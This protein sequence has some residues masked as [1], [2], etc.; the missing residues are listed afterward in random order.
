M[1]AAAPLF[2]SADA[3]VEILLVHSAI[4]A[5][6]LGV[7]VI[8]LRTL[9]VLR[10]TGEALPGLLP[11]MWF[12][13]LTEILR[14][15]WLGFL[16]LG[17]PAPLSLDLLAFFT[18]FVV[19]VGIPMT[20]S[21]RYLPKESA[22]QA[23]PLSWRWLQRAMEVIALLG[24]T[25]LLFGVRYRIMAPI[26]LGPAAAYLLISLLFLGRVLFY[27]HLQVRRRPLLLFATFMVTGLLVVSV[28]AIYSILSGVRIRQSS[29]LSVFNAAGLTLILCAVVFL[30][31]N[32]RLADVVVKRCLAIVACTCASVTTWLAMTHCT[33]LPSRSRG[34]PR[35]FLCLGIIC[36]VIALSPVA[37][38]RLNLWVDAWVFQQPDFSAA[39]ARVWREIL[40]LRDQEEVFAK[41][42]RLLQE[43]LGLAAVNIIPTAAGAKGESVRDATTPSLNTLV[44]IFLEGKT[45]HAIA[46]RVG[47]VRPPLTQL[48]L[49]FVERVAGRI[50]I[51]LG[52]LLAAERARREALFREE[53]TSAELRALRAQV[54]PHFLFNSLN[55]IA[56]LAVIA[57]SRAEEMT[58]RLS[59][60]FRY[61]LVNTDRHFAS[62]NE[63]LEFARS[64]LDIE[65]MRFG[66]R[67]QVI[68]D[69]DPTTLSQPIPTLLL[70]PL[71]ENALK[72][73]L[74]PRRGGGTLVIASRSSGESISI[75]IADNGA[76]LGQKKVPSERSTGVGV[77]NVTNRLKLAYGGRAS[78]VLRPRETGGAEALIIIPKGQ[79][80]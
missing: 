53:L 45:E 70:Q 75:S 13:L 4:A 77:E 66:D 14:A 79:E 71:I 26:V 58:L 52:T 38:R 57:P 5:M 18:S 1:P 42:E 19:L 72:H 69:I 78:F 31:A 30:F 3:T 56:D 44:P 37:M 33:M 15:I 49:D 28:N 10:R 40:D 74:A 73:G 65:Q 46:L 59:A 55:T 2:I 61:V 24:F 62:L 35:E 9:L 76:G 29:P 11:M 36:A 32:L 41:A 12:M 7:T 50:Q 48:E 20:V 47:A 22:S 25:V 34:A 21:A 60:V 39:A 6:G 68:F 64:Y 23:A 63:E 8:L 51:R 80:A 43:V 16:W 54:D 67:L 27:R 17:K